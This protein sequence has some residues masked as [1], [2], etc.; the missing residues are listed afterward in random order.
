MSET[1]EPEVAEV[2]E[3]VA[4]T[5]SAV[6]GE[7]P[8]MDERTALGELILFHGG[9]WTEADYEAL[10]DGV[11]AELH[12][13]R[14]ILVPSPSAEHMMASG[15]LY[16]RLREIVG[17]RRRVLQEVDVRMADGHRYRRPDVL[18][19]QEPAR[20]RPMDPANVVLVCE[21]ISPSGGDERQEKMTAYAEAG[22]EWYLITEETADGYLGELH[23]L[24]DGRYELLVKAPPAGTL[25]LPAPFDSAIDLRTLS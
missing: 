13:G 6:S 8:S 5:E 2:S 17:D 21:I 16:V 11:R 3:A 25:T 19:L 12:D 23:R 7:E 18:V 9:E 22:I 10:P 1:S 14:L 24:R 4:M 20:G 15:E